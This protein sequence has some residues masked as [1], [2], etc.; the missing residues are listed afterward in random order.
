[1]MIEKSDMYP[2]Y[3]GTQA[4]AM[5]LASSIIVVLQ[6]CAVSEACMLIAFF[7]VIVLV[8][9]LKVASM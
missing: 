7:W 8:I 6:A 5:Y 3:F 9:G 4:I 2:W 1:V